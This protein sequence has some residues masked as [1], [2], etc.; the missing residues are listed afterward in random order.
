MSQARTSPTRSLRSDGLA[1]AL[2]AGSLIER[3]TLTLGAGLI[4]FLMFVAY[5]GAMAGLC[6]ERPIQR[7]RSARPPG[8]SEAEL[9]L[10]SED[11]KTRK[12]LKYLPNTWVPRAAHMMETVDGRTYCY[13]QEWAK[14]SPKVLK[15][16]PFAM[17]SRRKGDKPDDPPYTVISDKAY[18]TFKD[19][20]GP[21]GK[22]PGP[23]LQAGL[24]GNVVITGP[25]NLVIHGRNFNFER[26]EMRIYSDNPVDIKADKHHATAKGIQIELVADHQGRGDDSLSIS[27]VSSVKLLQNVNMTL[28]SSGDSPTNPLP[29]V[30][31]SNDKGPKIIRTHCDGSFVFWAESRIGTFERNVRIRRETMPGKFDS[32]FADESVEITFEQQ[33]PDA[34]NVAPNGNALKSDAAKKSDGAAGITKNVTVAAAEKPNDQQGKD[35]KEGTTNGKTVAPHPGGLEPNLSFKSIHAQG[36]VVLLTS[37]VNE[38]RSQMRDFTYDQPA[39]EAKLIWISREGDNAER[40]VRDKE[41]RVRKIPAASDCVWVTQR[42]NVLHSQKIQL[43]HDPQGEVTHVMCLGEGGMQHV[44]EKSHQ[45]DLAAYWHQEMRKYPDPES[46]NFDRIDLIEALIEQPKQE[47]GLS[48]NSIRLW[49]TRQNRTAQTSQANRPQAPRQQ[50]QAEGP[51]LDHMLAWQKV[52]MVS[53]QMECETDRLE[54]WF[55]DAPAP[56][57]Y[58]PAGLTRQRGDLQPTSDYVGRGTPSTP[59][60][61]SPAIRFSDDTSNG[62]VLAGSNVNGGPAASPASGRPNA[63]TSIN[64]ASPNVAAPAR[65]NPNALFPGAGNGGDPY[66]LTAGH[67]RVHVLQF[68]DGQQPQ[69]ADML[70]WDNVQLTQVHGDAAEPL[71]V[72]GNVL[73]AHNRSETDQEMIVLG[74]PAHVRDRGAHIE[75]GRI[76]FNR[77]RNTADVDG[78]GRLQL[79]VQNDPEIGEAARPKNGEPAQPLDVAWHQKM[80]FDGKTAHFYVNVHTSMVDATSKSEIRCL[81]MDVTLSKP[82]SFT[83]EQRPQNEADRPAVQ[84]VFC[85]GD[86]EFESE[87]TQDNRLDEIRHGRFMDLVFH[88]QTGKCTASGPGQLRIWRRNEHGQ[89]GLASVMNVQ[90]NA[91]PKAHKSS[92][93]EF[94]Q[95]NFQGTMNGDF[96]DLLAGRSRPKSAAAP[97]IQPTSATSSILATNGAWSAQF[98]TRVEVIYGPVDQPREIVSREE[99]S[100]ESGCLLCESLQVTQLPQSGSVP[101]HIEMVARGNSRIEGKTFWGESDTI[102]YDGSKS[103][104]VLIGDAA[105][106]A[107]LWR[108]L[109]IGGAPNTNAAYRIY[110]NPITHSVREEGGQKIDIAQ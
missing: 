85:Q 60:S 70:A 68:P 105:A 39:S 26:E 86:V 42:G 62:F 58:R 69:V 109:K 15:F 32:L 94:N 91:P 41:G 56:P 64:A 4:L 24:E 72:S 38:M 57:R 59:R 73:E 6:P 89:S 27:G 13:F 75:G 19:E 9:Y 96:R 3:I 87:A 93:F 101:Q 71:A 36:K 8:D 5:R 1:V 23:V 47:S 52:V 31:K 7:T 49:L 17:I 74:Q 83:Q 35:K 30:A 102:T 22:N 51:H 55:E 108:Q 46:K 63:G 104:Y 45:V 10:N 66:N 78:P 81:N 98:H 103:Q 54:V 80:H 48:A 65:A 25:N 67:V 61:T 44:E 33:K 90:S 28:V 77:A 88:K 97:K 79:P 107:R 99:L 50:P 82:F 92:A 95:V 43:N 18:V 106:L 40:T 53:P 2:F 37:D 14:E 84:T 11:Q 21:L 29:G 34:K 12:A 20:V 16:T 110:F 76:R 100:D